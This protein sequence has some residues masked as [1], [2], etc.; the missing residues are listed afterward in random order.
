[1]MGDEEI[2]RLSRELVDTYSPH[3]KSQI[4]IPLTEKHYYILSISKFILL[5]ESVVKKDEIE[6]ET[7]EG[8]RK[9][10]LITFNL[11]ENID[12][13]NSIQF[14]IDQIGEE[15]NLNLKALLQ[16][17]SIKD[18][19]RVTIL[20]EGI[21]NRLHIFSEYLDN[22]SNHDL[23]NIKFYIYFYHTIRNQLAHGDYKINSDKKS[24]ELSIKGN[25][26]NIPISLL[27]S[28]NLIVG[29]NSY[30]DEYLSIFNKN[31]LKK[32]EPEVEDYY[33]KYYINKRKN[34]N[35]Y[36]HNVLDGY[37]LKKKDPLVQNI[38][39][40]INEVKDISKIIELLKKLRRQL[41]SPTFDY[42]TIRGNLDELEIKKLIVLID[43][44]TAD[45]LEKLGE[46]ALNNL[47]VREII[48]E[49]SE[50]LGVRTAEETPYI[51]SL[52]NYCQIVAARIEKSDDYSLIH[53][54]RIIKTANPLIGKDRDER[55]DV[56]SANKEIGKA[57]RTYNRQMEKYQSADAIVGRLNATF[58]LI[59]ELL[60]KLNERNQALVKV[61]RNS[62]QHGNFIPLKNDDR[63][64]IRLI[65]QSKHTDDS[66]INF[67]YTVD[68]NDL[69][70]T[71]Q[72]VAIVPN[73]MFM[74]N[75]DN[76]NL[77]FNSSFT[78]NN[79]Y[80]ELEVIVSKEILDKVKTN[81]NTFLE[82]L[83]YKNFE[84][85][86]ILNLPLER[87]FNDIKSLRNQ[88]NKMGGKKS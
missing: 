52:Y 51:A 30:S 22:G 53:M 61:I 87:V 25:S 82:D 66:T 32:Y 34:N 64:N 63:V 38:S 83:Y 73:T 67:D 81:L 65:D 1:M 85:E 76:E 62:I 9:L 78:L 43:S 6:I 8:K 19:P 55:K 74:Q 75:Y 27:N 39:N 42:S 31:I 79:L 5:K 16:I 37:Y 13:F 12:F 69:Y 40:D 29:E 57:C 80:E 56:V 14:F 88:N 10:E 28:I 41:S 3:N 18:L 46:S 44:L 86:E 26:I 2:L 72:E 70:E 35:E 21:T 45:N 54:S 23:E 24:I 68:S 7:R 71:M 47:E 77:I 33:N 60:S 15:N 48:D 11:A 84:L 50:I 49:I 58:K 36:L 20:P 59:T 4:S 17:F